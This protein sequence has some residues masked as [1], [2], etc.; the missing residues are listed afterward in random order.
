VLSVFVLRS[1]CSGPWSVVRSSTY[2]Y[3]HL[4]VYN[5]THLYWEQLLDEGRGGK[6]PLWIIKKSKRLRPSA[7]AAEEAPTKEVEIEQ[8]ALE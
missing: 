8:I 5:S 7:T 2:G 1:V 3:G 4:T 6:D